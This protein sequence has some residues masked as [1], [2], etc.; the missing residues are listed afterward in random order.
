MEGMATTTRV[1][2]D[3]DVI[4]RWAEQRHARPTF[5]KGTGILRL[6][7]PGYSGEGKLQPKA[8]NDFFKRFD[9]SNLAFVYQDRTARGQSSNFNK[10]VGRETVNLA[11]GETKTAPPR[12]QRKAQ[13]RTAA[14]TSSRAAKG[15]KRT[16][17]KTNR[18]SKHGTPSPRKGA[19]STK[20]TGRSATRT[21]KPRS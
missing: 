9:E 6:D 7:F 16:P 18:A 21:G 15:A 4:R 10:L 20:S 2:I 3:H 19:K 11:S 8:W 5:V 17:P 13:S 14:A 1:T 12:R